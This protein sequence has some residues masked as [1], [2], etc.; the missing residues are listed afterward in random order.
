MSADFGLVCSPGI[1]SL[2]LVLDGL[3]VGSHFV[4]AIPTLMRVLVDQ[5]RSQDYECEQLEEFAL[6]VLQCARTQNE[7][8]KP[9]LHSAD[10]VSP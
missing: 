4:A 8:R 7:W 10:P 3:D 6:P 5:I 9:A 2:Q 1:P